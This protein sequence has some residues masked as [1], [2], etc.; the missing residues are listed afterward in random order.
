MVYNVEDEE[1]EKFYVG[2]TFVDDQ[3][4]LFYIQNYRS[5]YKWLRLLMP[6]KIRKRFK[7][8]IVPTGDSMEFAEMQQ[9][10]YH[11]AICMGDATEQFID[12]SHIYNARSI[13]DLFG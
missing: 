5:S 4:N 8:K 7:L 11:Q 1:L 6:K 3:G 10:M 9:H 12:L 13:R 2:H